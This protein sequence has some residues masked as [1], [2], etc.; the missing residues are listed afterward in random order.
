MKHNWLRGPRYIQGP[1]I[2]VNFSPTLEGRNDYCW[3][4]TDGLIFNS[5]AARFYTFELIFV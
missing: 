5:D 1:R 3:E 2:G 4:V